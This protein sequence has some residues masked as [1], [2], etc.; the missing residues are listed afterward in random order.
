MA[1]RV[2]DLTNGTPWKIIILFAIPIV[3]SYLLQQAYMLADLWM[4]G[5]MLSETSFAAIG[6]T[7][8]LNLF[9]LMFATG[10]ATGFSVIT[11]QRFGKG[12][13]DSMKKSYITGI[14]LS[15]IIGLILTVLSTILC[16]PMLL[17]VNVSRTDIK[18]NDSYNYIMIIFAGILANL[19]YNYFSSILRAVGNTKMPL[20]FLILSAVLNIV[21]NYLLLK[22]TKLGVIGPAIGTVISQLVSAIVSFI[23]IQIKYPEFKITFKELHL[24][25]EEV[26]AHLKQGLPMGVQF[27][28]LYIALIVLQREVNAFGDGAIS[29]YSAA[30]KVDALFMQP[31]N[32]IGT[33]M[34]TYVGQNYGAKKYNRIKKG[35]KQI[36]VVQLI[37]VAIMTIAVFSIKDIF[38]HILVKNPSEDTI[39]YAPIFMGFIA[40]SQLALGSIFLFRNCLQA[41]GCSMHAMIVSIVQCFTRAVFAITFPMILGIYGVAIATPISWYI[42]AVL[43]FLF[44]IFKIFKKLPNDDENSFEVASNNT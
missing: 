36:S 38:I 23:Y 34:V 22:F 15:I 43:L 26:A 25:K 18:F 40:L 27:S 37:L 29:A 5:N 20:V 4:I 35:I 14:L 42:S 24:A 17:L 21:I 9:V 1:T 13:M 10:T 41:A 32:A 8:P 2:K 19:F 7:N 30:N 11:S 33:A 44:T 3:I 28:F 31:L 6:T 16:E 39:K 12:D